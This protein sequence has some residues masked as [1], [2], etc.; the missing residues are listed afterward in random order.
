MFRNLALLIVFLAFCAVLAG[1]FVRLSDAGLACPDWPG[2]FGQLA[3]PDSRIF[4]DQSGQTPG[5]LPPDLGKARISM[6]HRYLAASTAGLIIVLW[7]AA[8]FLR[9]HRK[10]AILLAT[11][12]AASVV[13]QIALGM[14]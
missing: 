6:S 1:A 14:G 3:M 13:L 4:T 5:G 11:L 9:L 8:F 10:T 7:L 2:C 12:L